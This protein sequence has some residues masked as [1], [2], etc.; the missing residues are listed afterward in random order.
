MKANSILLQMKYSRII[1]LFAQKCNL[2]LDQALDFFY[3]SKEYQLLREGVADLHCMSDDYIA[4]D[5]KDEYEES[6][7]NQQKNI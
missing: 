1:V 6:R 5:L 4:E 7:N 2:T 3:Y